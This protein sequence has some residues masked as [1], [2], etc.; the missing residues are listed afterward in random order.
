MDQEQLNRIVQTVRSDLSLSE[1]HQA[2]V[3][4]YTRRAVNRAL[5][6]CNRADLP[7]QA[8]DVAAQI[9]EDMLRY[10]QISPAENDVSSVSRGDTTISYRDKSSAYK[11]TVSF[12][13]NYESQLIPFKKMKLPEDKS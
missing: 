7:E 9:V 4:R 8:E 3:L 11:E 1:E 10:D 13:K 2:T 12:V 5:V 6:F